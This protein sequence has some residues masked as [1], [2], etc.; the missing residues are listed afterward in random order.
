VKDPVFSH[1][2]TSHDITERFQNTQD[3]TAMKSQISLAN[4]GLKNISV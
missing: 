2:T 3:Y 1:Q 4:I